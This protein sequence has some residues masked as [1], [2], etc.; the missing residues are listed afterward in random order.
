MKT[1][2]TAYFRRGVREST[3]TMNRR[4]V[5]IDGLSCCR[6]ICLL[7]RKISA[8]RTIDA[9][10][11]ALRTKTPLASD[12]LIEIFVLNPDLNKSFHMLAAHLKYLCAIGS[13]ASEMVHERN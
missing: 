1:H 13:H 12:S 4:I 8:R 10:V 9:S 7:H 6:C 11:N 3:N 2:H 5:A